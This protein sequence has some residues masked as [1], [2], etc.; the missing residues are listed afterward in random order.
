MVA[1]ACLYSMNMRVDGQDCKVAQLSA[2]GTDPEFR[3]QGLA[4]D[5]NLQAIEW[6][7]DQHDF[8]YLFADTEAFRLY[9]TCSFRRVVERKS[10]IRV[11]GRKR[12]TGIRKLDTNKPDD[13]DL[14]YRI[15]CERTP[16]SNLLGVNN[17][18]LFMFWCLYFLKENVYYI[19]ELDLLVLYERKDD[20]VTVFDIV[21]RA[22]PEF[23]DVYPFI[24]KPTDRQVEFSFMP[25]RL[26]IGE[27]ESVSLGLETGTHLSGEFELEENFIIPMTAKA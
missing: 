13:R 6:A 14:I 1:N 26:N 18:K 20:L 2:V 15:A 24:A 5:L 12:A 19:E 21:G 3:H 17:P 7:K 10:R 23:S 25:D 22:M 27:C 11:R 9:E 8:Y 4:Y 16:V